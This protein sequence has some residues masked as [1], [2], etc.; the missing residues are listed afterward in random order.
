MFLL[1]EVDFIIS[2]QI[3]TRYTDVKAVHQNGYDWTLRLNDG[4]RWEDIAG[5]YADQW[6]TRRAR[7]VDIVI[8]L[9]VAR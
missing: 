9:S 3:N 2:K 6:T 8:I 1:T 4:R 5:G 7:F